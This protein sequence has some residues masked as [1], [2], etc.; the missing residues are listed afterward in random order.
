MLALSCARLQ[1]EFSMMDRICFLPRLLVAILVATLYAVPSI[2]QSR[3]VDLT[4]AGSLNL[5]ATL[6]SA[7]SRGPG[8]LLLHQC[9][10]QPTIW[11]DLAKQLSSAALLV[12]AVDV[13]G[14]RCSGGCL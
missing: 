6:F 5:K 10:R 9:N 14:I 3:D 7:S 2:A 13:S 8:V 12:M 1:N 11:N 4:G